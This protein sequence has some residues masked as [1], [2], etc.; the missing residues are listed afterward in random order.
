MRASSGG[1]TKSIIVLMLKDQW[2][3][4]SLFRDFQHNSGF[5]IVCQLKSMQMKT[6]NGGVGVSGTDDM[7]M[8]DE[9]CATSV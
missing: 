5:E 2:G 4:H 8:D 7:V 3:Q 6:T 1:F 9:P